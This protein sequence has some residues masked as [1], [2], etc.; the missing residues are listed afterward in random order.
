M[1][2]RTDGTIEYSLPK[3]IVWLVEYRL[4]YQAPY[5]VGIASSLAEAK[6]LVEKYRYPAPEKWTE[7]GM[8]WQHPD[9]ETM[10]YPEGQTGYIQDD[11][12]YNYYTITQWEL[13]S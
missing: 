11:G 12:S 1:T 6:I 8:E 2:K 4:P 9:N 5:I 3:R 13:N 7:I 10:P